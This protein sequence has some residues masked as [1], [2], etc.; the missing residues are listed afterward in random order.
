MTIN[1]YLA[2]VFTITLLHAVHLAIIPDPFMTDNLY[3]KV[4][5]AE[6]WRVFGLLNRIAHLIQLPDQARALDIG[7]FNGIS[8]MEIALAFPEVTQM[9]GIDMQLPPRLKRGD[10]ISKIPYLEAAD[11]ERLRNMPINFI[12]GDAY[13]YDN[14]QH[15]F[16]LIV[17]AHNILNVLSRQ[18]LAVPERTELAGKV[19]QLVQFLEPNGYMILCRQ[20]DSRSSYILLQKVANAVIK[21]GDQKLYWQN[22]MLHPDKAD[23]FIADINKYLQSVCES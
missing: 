5:Y 8:T 10:I 3:H 16:H 22:H 6:A 12:P 15:K 13:T 11:V 4:Q 23:K 20:A 21:V 18:T 7:C 9:T 17:A 19:A 1:A 14:Y 2:T